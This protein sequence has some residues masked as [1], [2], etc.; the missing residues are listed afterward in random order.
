MNKIALIVP[1][2]LLVNGVYDIACAAGILWL[3]DTPPFRFLGRIHP[4]MF[5]DSRR[6]HDPALQRMMAYWILSAGITRT[7]AGLAFPNRGLEIAAA[8]SFLVEAI[9]FYNEYQKGSMHR[10]KVGVVVCLSVLF[11]VI[12]LSNSWFTFTKD[13]L[14]RL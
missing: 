8:G 7:I 4:T 5:V 9:C 6:T 11:A 3:Q 13:I 2:L 14:G 10:W 12:V 1:I